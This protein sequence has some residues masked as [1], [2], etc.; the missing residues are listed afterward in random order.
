MIMIT[1]NFEMVYYIMM[2]FYMYLMA[3]DLKKCQM[4]SMDETKKP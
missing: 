4:F 3:Y 1:S 2:G